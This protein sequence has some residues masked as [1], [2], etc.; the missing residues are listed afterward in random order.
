MDLGLE[1]GLGICAIAKTTVLNWPQKSFSY[2][3]SLDMKFQRFWS[4]LK[5]VSTV[6]VTIGL[7]A[8]SV[9]IPGMTQPCQAQSGPEGFVSSTYRVIVDSSNNRILEQ[10]MQVE[11]KAFMRNFTDGKMRI[12]AGAFGTMEKAR[13][14]VDAL[15]R[16]GIPSTAFD[17]DW[18]PVY[19]QMPDGISN[20]NPGSGSGSAP[21][22]RP[23]D[24]QQPVAG[25]PKGY[26]AVVPIDRDMVGITYEKLRKLGIEESF[27]TV[28]QANKGWHLSVGVYP[29][30]DGA[31]QMAVYLRDKGGMDARTYYER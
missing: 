10:V 20:Y 8:V 3:Y 13:E 31:E 30:R 7:L 12:Q 17:R 6:G 28:G 26:Y 15:A 22:P 9:T 29:N 2:V 19:A 27:I 5:Y 25:M 18:R 24:A 1:F 23:G 14:Q 11:P 16:V 4:G 21:L